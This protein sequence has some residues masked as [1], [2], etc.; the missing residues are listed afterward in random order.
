MIMV[1]EYLTIEQAVKYIDSKIEYDFS[2]INLRELEAFKI[3]YPIFYF[4]G[5]A[6]FEHKGLEFFSDIEG[7]FHLNNNE[8]LITDETIEFETCL[9]YDATLDNFKTYRIDGTRMAFKPCL[10]LDKNAIEQEKIANFSREEKT[11]TVNPYKHS[12][13]LVC[14]EKDDD[15]G[16]GYIISEIEPNNVRVNKNQLDKWLTKNDTPKEL[17]EAKAKIT[18]LTAE[19]DRLNEKLRQKADTSTDDKDL[20]PKRLNTVARLLNVLFYKAGY[21]PSAHQGTIN[22]NIVTLS[23]TLG[24]SITEKPVSYWIKEVQQLRIN[25]ERKK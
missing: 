22:T 13:K 4:K 7:Y 10:Y 2:L 14:L 24:A 25:T 12:F 17:E 1:D 5:M 21:D 8:H 11:L 20:H 6:S 9:L 16:D 19:N 23:D 18:E 3:I 15:D